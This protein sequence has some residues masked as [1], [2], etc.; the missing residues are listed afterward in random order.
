[1]KNKVL[2]LIICAAVLLPIL[3]LSVFADGVEDD[4][5]EIL[6]EFEMLAERLASAFT[7][8]TDVIRFS[9]HL[10]GTLTA[11]FEIEPI[12]EG[13]ISGKKMLSDTQ[14]RLTNVTGKD[15][16]KVPVDVVCA[17]AEKTGLRINYILIYVSGRSKPC[18]VEWID[19]KA[20]PEDATWRFN[21][22]SEDI[23]ESTFDMK[24]GE[25]VEFIIIKEVG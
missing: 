18:A 25:F 7:P 1:M 9:Y 3:S 19:G 12:A 14:F 21:P 22:L 10:R 17:A 5:F 4:N 11:E 8:R 16:T 13:Q 2:S 20:Y 6:S 24:D 15:L 23:P